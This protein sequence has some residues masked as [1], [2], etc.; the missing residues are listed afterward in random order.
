MG[1]GGAGRDD[2]NDFFVLSLLER[3]DHYKDRSRPNSPNRY[4]SFLVVKCLIPLRDCEWIVEGQ[5]RGLKANVVLAKVP[6]VLGFVPFESHNEPR[7]DQ[8]IGSPALSQY[9]C[10][11][12]HTF[13]YPF[14]DPLSSGVAFTLATGL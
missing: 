10:T 2:A 6:P 11:Y 8:D 4:P 5:S 9:M 7:S 1:L 14:I 3:M 12:N 13:S